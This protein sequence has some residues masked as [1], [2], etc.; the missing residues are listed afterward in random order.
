MPKSMRFSLSLVVA[1]LLLVSPWAGAVDRPN[2][3]K[4]DM[5]HPVTKCQAGCKDKKTA[6]SYEECM[7]KC[8]QTH[9]GNSPALPQPRK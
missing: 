1:G 8:R 5:N 7:I 6:E 9:K 3:Q 4:L 2:N